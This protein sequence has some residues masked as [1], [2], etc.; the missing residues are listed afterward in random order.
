MS[1]TWAFWFKKIH[2]LA[3]GM[4]WGT[5]HTGKVKDRPLK[6]VLLLR[7]KSEEGERKSF[8]NIRG[9]GNGVVLRVRPIVTTAPT[10]D[11]WEG[12]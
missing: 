11:R 8:K 5:R 3:V 2:L 10:G 12:G 6:K 7:L 4:V 1:G 9:Q